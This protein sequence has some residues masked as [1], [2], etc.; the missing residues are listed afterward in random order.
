MSRGYKYEVYFD[1]EKGESTVSF[2][3]DDVSTIAFKFDINK[4]DVKIV[5]LKL[6]KKNIEWL[7]I[8]SEDTGVISNLVKEIPD[9]KSYKYL[10]RKKGE[11][12]YERLESIRKG[13][14]SYAF[15]DLG[16]TIEGRLSAIQAYAKGE[17][18]FWSEFTGNSKLGFY[19]HKNF[20]WQNLQKVRE[21]M[22]LFKKYIS[23]KLGGFMI[24]VPSM[25]L[26]GGV[27]GTYTSQ[28][29]AIVT[30]FLPLRTGVHEYLHYVF[31]LFKS[32]MEIEKSLK[33]IITAP[34]ISEQ[35]AV[36]EYERSC[37][38]YGS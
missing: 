32:L 20:Q 25:A 2:K 37:A 28:S 9:E 8:I 31:D 38:K 36:R 29:T 11:Q 24:F 23:D 35:L 5:D 19:Y 15:N 1:R 17:I 14:K 3:K 33:N 13:S 30:D 18:G 27:V 7:K 12:A 10:W 6:V 22:E 26:K 4:R 16:L 34:L 21:K